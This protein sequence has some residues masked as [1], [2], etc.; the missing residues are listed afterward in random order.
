M[1]NVIIGL[2]SVALV[3]AGMIAYLLNGILSKPK[4][5][6]S[7]Q[8]QVE[9]VETRVTAENFVL[10]AKKSLP[11][12]SRISSSDVKWQAWSNAGVPDKFF[13]STSGE[14]DVPQLVNG[15]IV[16]RAFS[17]GEP[18][19][20]GKIYSIKFQVDESSYLAGVMS[21][22]K[23]A[24]T[25]AVNAES[26]LSGF[27]FPGDYVDI[28]L[29]HDTPSKLIRIEKVASMAAVAGSPPK[30]VK[31]VSETILENIRVLAIDQNIN[32]IKKDKPVVAKFITFE[33]SPNEAA[34]IAAAKQMGKLSF[35]LRSLE[36]EKDIS[37]Q[38]LFAT[39]VD[40][41]PLLKGLISNPA[42]SGLTKTRL[43]TK[44]RS[45]TTM[46]IYRG[47]DLTT[48]TFRGK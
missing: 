19:V 48:Q 46:K 5:S 43:V 27:V 38:A 3:A 16:R 4:S 22:G 10:L 15:A 26:G 23:R 45:V 39:D 36:S 11:A 1:R 14:V 12:G 17:E 2:M 35:S 32:D 6:P 8:S 33:V 20:S 7:L 42:T 47:V 18:I 13:S 25:I 24:A 37:E 44:T 28:I 30:I 40:V 9:S 34:I 31:F 41:S 21:P 29:T